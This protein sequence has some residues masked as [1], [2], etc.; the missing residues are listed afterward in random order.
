VQQWESHDAE[1]YSEPEN[2]HVVGGAE[3]QGVEDQ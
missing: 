3:T 1:E 2:G